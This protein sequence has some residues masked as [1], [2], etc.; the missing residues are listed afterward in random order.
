MSGRGPLLAIDGDNC[1]HRAF[2]ALPQT[3]RDASGHPA[4]MVVGFADMLARLWESTRPRAVFVGFDTPRAPT[5]RQGLLPAYQ[6]GRDF[7]DDDILMAQLDRLPELVEALGIAWAR[8]EGY[9]ADDFLATVVSHEEAAGGTALVF[10]NDRDLFQLVSEH[11]TILHPRKGTTELERVGPEEVEARYGVTPEQVPDFIALRGDPSD[12]I[13]GARGIGP[14]KAARI[15]RE[16]GSLEGAIAAGRFADEEAA[17]LRVYLQV[18][19][20]Q[21]DAPVPS[22]PDAEPA[23]EPGADLAERWGLG[24]LAGR[25]RRLATPRGE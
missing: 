9:E 1:A 7:V 20:A 22:L 14:A 25:L 2:H 19:T 16:H 15:L 4:N 21:R 5:Y 13:P 23:W 8:K 12:R 18:A 24:G 10:S 17:V 6:S 11:V 3:I